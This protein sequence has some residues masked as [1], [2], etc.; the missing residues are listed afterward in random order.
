M[1]ADTGRLRVVA[2]E[3]ADS[4]G[5]AT[6][7][8]IRSPGSYVRDQRKRRGMSIEQLAAAT[9]IP[10]VQLELLEQDRV[11][12]LPGPVFAKGFLRCCARALDL[13]EETVLGLLY[14]QERAR[15]RA[16][17]NESSSPFLASAN[18]AATVDSGVFAPWVGVLR[19]LPVARL[20][21]WLIAGLL[22]AIVVLVAFG[23]SRGSL[24]VLT[25]S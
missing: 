7:E 3:A 17:R 6:P 11:S 25:N 1:R 8:V 4:L 5:I 16:R 12:E 19:R 22:I 9:K 21:T 24:D 23:L 13:D 18:K 20:L 14:E 10:R 2:D 15:L